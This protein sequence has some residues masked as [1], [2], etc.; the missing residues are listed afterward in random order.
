MKKVYY[1]FIGIFILALIFSYIF[2][3]L[4]SFIWLVIFISLI[5][6]IILLILDTKNKTINNINEESTNISKKDLFIKP[7]KIFLY[8]IVISSWIVLLL[9]IYDSYA[10]L[11]FFWTIPGVIVITIA[12]FFV[13]LFKY[14]SNK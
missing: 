11:F 2:W 14:Y 4:F 8:L 10:V 6:T 1:I 9:T 3:L 7:F 5:I 12:S 13:Y